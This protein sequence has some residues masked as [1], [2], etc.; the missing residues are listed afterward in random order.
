MLAGMLAFSRALDRFCPTSRAR[1]SP[2]NDVYDTSNWPEVIIPSA[3]LDRRFTLQSQPIGCQS[4]S[5]GHFT[6]VWLDLVLT[7]LSLIG[8]QV[9]KPQPG[10]RKRLGFEAPPNQLAANAYSCEIRF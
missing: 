7:L 2:L 1:P 8:F 3:R 5:N 10:N 9:S 6:I 4:V